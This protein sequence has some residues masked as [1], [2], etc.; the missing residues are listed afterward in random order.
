MF[1]LDYRNVQLGCPTI[2]YGTVHVIFGFYYHNIKNAINLVAWLLYDGT[3][4]VVKCIDLIP[5]KVF[6]TG[7]RGNL[8]AKGN[9][10]THINVETF[11][12]NMSI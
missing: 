7:K 6:Y 3:N 1:I 11:S 8:F 12:L 9:M 5:S 10:I 4:K 2:I